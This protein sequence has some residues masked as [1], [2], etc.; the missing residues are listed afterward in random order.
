MNSFIYRGEWFISMGASCFFAAA[1]DL[2]IAWSSVLFPNPPKWVFYFGWSYYLRNTF[3]RQAE[4][5]SN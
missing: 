3:L 2:A 5:L 1:A 4:K